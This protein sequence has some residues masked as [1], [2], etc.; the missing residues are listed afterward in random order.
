MKR[1]EDECYKI[2]QQTKQ[3]YKGQ[4]YRTR[5]LWKLKN[6]SQKSITKKQKLQRDIGGG[7]KSSNV[8][9]KYPRIEG[10]EFPE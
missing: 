10:H 1:L 3:K 2:S 7:K 5:K 4:K 6:Q 9:E 8:T